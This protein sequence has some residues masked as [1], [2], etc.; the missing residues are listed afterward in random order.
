M[1]TL[2]LPLQCYDDIEFSKGPIHQT[3]KLICNSWHKNNRQGKRK[4]DISVRQP[5]G[6]ILDNISRILPV[7]PCDDAPSPLILQ[8]Y[9]VCSSF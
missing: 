3:D 7:E 5:L 1:E 4:R 6:Q 8:R 9:F 2:P